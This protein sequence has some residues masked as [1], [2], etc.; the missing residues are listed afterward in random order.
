MS[1]GEPMSI[2]SILY[3]M[4]DYSSQRHLIAVLTYPPHR[5]MRLKS[6]PC[7]HHDVGSLKNTFE[8][9]M[10][11]AAVRQQH[12]VFDAERSGP[13]LSSLIMT[14]SCDLDR[15]CHIRRLC[16]A[17]HAKTPTCEGARALAGLRTARSCKTYTNNH[18]HPGGGF[19]V[20]PF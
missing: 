5:L 16:Q 15:R 19:V 12:L 6:C 10:R 11:E 8:R 3:S 9:K 2:E 20:P 13:S 17:W 14:P 4:H 18:K 1:A 7:H